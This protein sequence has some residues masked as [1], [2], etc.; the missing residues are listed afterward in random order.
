MKYLKVFNN[1]AEYQQ[2]KG[3][4]EYISPNISLNRETRNIEFEDYYI[5]ADIIYY[6][7]TDGEIITPNNEAFG[8]NV[9]IVSNTYKK[10]I[11]IMKFDAPITSI[12]ESAFF[13]CGTL[14]RVII[15]NSV[16][17]IGSLAFLDC[18]SLTGIT[19]PNSVTSIGNEAFRSCN[20]LTSVTIPD[21]V[22]KIKEGTFAWCDCLT[23][24]TIPNSV[25]SIGDG[26]FYYCRSLININCKATTPPTLGDISVFSY[27][28]SDRKIYVPTASVNAYKTAQYWSEYADYIVG[29]D[30]EDV[31]GE[32]ITFTIAGDEYQ[33]E[34]GMTWEEWVNSEYNTSNFLILGGVIQSFDNK[35]VNA[36]TSDIIRNN[37][38]Y[39]LQTG[40]SG[41]VD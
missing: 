28:L 19:I 15:P 29:Y 18:T 17:S 9:T 3:S 25:T 33:A 24:I 13:D 12:G 22:T 31:S 34:E 41:G 30:F 5:S 38:V 37:G 23:S 1:D 26:A 36:K 40:N 4:D 7:S 20:S 16:T 10:G 11:G 8:E 27:N 2:F 39:L 32:I 6:T 14:K 35:Y 21:S